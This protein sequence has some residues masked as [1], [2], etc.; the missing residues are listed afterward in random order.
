MGIVGHPFERVA[1]AV[2]EPDPR[3]GHE[4]DDG[5]RHEDL[6]RVREPL[7]ALGDVHDDPADVVAAQLDFARVYADADD[8]AESVDGGAYRHG[9]TQGTPRPVDAARLVPDR[10]R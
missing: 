2:G 4:V 10:A 7:H 5:S 6:V 8:D 3:T 9:A 1:A